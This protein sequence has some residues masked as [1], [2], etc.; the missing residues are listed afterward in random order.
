MRHTHI[1]VIAK[2]GV[3]MPMIQKRAGHRKMATTAEYYVHIVDDKE[4]TD[5][6]DDIVVS[7]ET[8]EVNNGI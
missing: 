8:K 7:E 3:P 2:A 5:T 1:T 4:A 6:F